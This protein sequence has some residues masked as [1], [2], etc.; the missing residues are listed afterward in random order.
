MSGAID[1]DTKVGDD[2][3]RALRGQEPRYGCADPAATPGDDR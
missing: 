2:Y 1:R 3:R